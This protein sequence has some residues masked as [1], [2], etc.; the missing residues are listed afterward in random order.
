VVSDGGCDPDCRLEDLG[1]AIR[2]VRVDLGVPIEL[3]RFD[4]HPRKNGEQ[5]KHC[6]VGEILYDWVDGPQAG[7]GTIIYIK[8]SITGDEPRDVLNYKETSPESRS[9]VQRIAV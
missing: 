5:G 2:K 4:I 6:A 7:R 1:N 9:M 8:P 3:R